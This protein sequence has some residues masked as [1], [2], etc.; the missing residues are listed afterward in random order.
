MTTF[1]LVHGAWHGAWCWERLIP[2][3]EQHGHAALAIELPCEDPEAGCVAYAAVVSAGIAGVSDDVV[4]VGHSLG[5]LT[6]PLVVAERPV[7]KL[8]FLCALIPRPGLS[9][10][11]QLAQEPEIFAPGFGTGLARDE[12][13]RSYWTDE[14]AAIEGLYSDCPRQLAS[15][16]V[17]RLRHQAR[18]PSVEPCPLARWPE[19]ESI[20]IFTAADAAINPLWARTAAP[21]RLGCEA[22]E[23]PGDHS[24]FL[25]RPAELAEA[26]VSVGR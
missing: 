22:I 17:A 9:L 18:A 16:A 13:D 14:D 12:L 2:E 7:R 10:T 5:G 11:D 3:L 6:I 19:V 8:V 21:E 15:W 26:L 24:P 25:A 4:L 23:L 1:A 20:S